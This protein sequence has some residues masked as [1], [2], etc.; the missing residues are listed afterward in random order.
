MFETNLLYLLAVGPLTGFLGCFSY[1]GLV[2]DPLAFGSNLNDFLP[3]KPY[4]PLFF[5]DGALFPQVMFCWPVA[6]WV[7]RWYSQS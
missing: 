5:P 2:F 7:S 4:V 3:G 1:P 6:V